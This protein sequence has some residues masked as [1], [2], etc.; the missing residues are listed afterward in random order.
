MTEGASPSKSQSLVAFG[1]SANATVVFAIRGLTRRPLQTVL[2]LFALSIA[3]AGTMTIMAVLSGIKE[4]MRRDL[5]QVGLDVINVHI[6]PNLKNLMASA[7]RLS[8]CDWMREVTGGTVAPFSATMGV[9]DAEGTVAGAGSEPVQALLLQTTS[10]WGRIVPLQWTEGR[11][12][13][14]DEKGVCVLDEWVA[15][16]LFPNGHASG[17]TVHVKWLGLPQSFR[18]VGVMRDP[19]EIRKRFDEL[20]VTGS[21]RSRILRMMEFK[22]IYVPG[23][24]TR[25]EQSIH[26][27]VIKVPAGRDPQAFEGPLMQHLGDRRSTVWVWSRKQ[28][29]GNVIQAANFGTQIANVVWIIV[30]VVTGV[31]IAT[32]SLVAIRERYREIAIRRTEGARRSQIIGQLLFENILLTGMSGTLAYFLA[33]AGGVILR[34]RYIS[35]PPA[36]LPGDVLLALGVGVLLAALATVLPARRAASLDP[37]EVLRNA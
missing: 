36:F 22:S 18:V 11:F 26:G 24:F 14:P 1:G 3:L 6:S 37:V 27:S 7:L 30:L 12:F 32:V 17:Q 16:K 20:D 10:D 8:D 5:E 19:F 25:P 4:Q 29:I 23:N 13:E 9:A 15:K 35:W 31:M 34:E 28:W 2:L 33:R 21:A